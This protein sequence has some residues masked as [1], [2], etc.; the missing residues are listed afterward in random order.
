[1]KIYVFLLL[2][3]SSFRNQK[4][5]GNEL[6]DKLIYMFC[7]LL[8]KSNYSTDKKLK[9]FNNFVITIRG[10]Q[11]NQSERPPPFGKP[12][13]ETPPRPPVDSDATKLIGRWQANFVENGIQVRVIWHLQAEGKMRYQIMSNRGSYELSGTWKYSDGVIYERHENG[14]GGQ[15]AIKWIDNNHIEVTILDPRGMKLQYYR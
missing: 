12:E 4:V 10:I 15:E 9:E 8:Q 7:T 6:K 2:S 5:S 1:M 14:A 13:V 3:I 11:V